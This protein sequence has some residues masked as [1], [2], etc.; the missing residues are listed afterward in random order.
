MTKTLK[1]SVTL[2]DGTVV[3]VGG[4]P[5]EVRECVEF[6][7]IESQQRPS[8]SGPSKR[9]PVRSSVSTKKTGA[10]RRR[11]GLSL[12]ER[13]D[14]WLERHREAMRRLADL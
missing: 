4:T 2:P 8:G 9:R 1:A 14:R 13:A 5:E 3:Q 11:T 7:R 10:T 12:E 6:Y